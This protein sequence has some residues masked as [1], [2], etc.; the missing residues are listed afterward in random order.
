MPE[1]GVKARPSTQFPSARVSSPRG[2]HP[3]CDI[4]HSLPGNFAPLASPVPT[5]SDRCAA[6]WERN[7]SSL[8]RRRLLRPPDIHNPKYIHPV[9]LHRVVDQ[10]QVVRSWQVRVHL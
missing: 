10:A 8:G 7:S 9:A 4:R 5:N 3:A 1:K 6:A 2:S